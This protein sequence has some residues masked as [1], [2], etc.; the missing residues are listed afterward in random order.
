MLS[1]EQHELM[2]DEHGFQGQRRAVS[3]LVREL[4]REITPQEIFVPIEHPPGAEIQIDWG[5]ADFILNGVT[6]RVMLFCARLP[7]SKATYVRAYMREDQ[8]SFLDAHVHLIDYLKGVPHTFAYDNLKSAVTK[9]IGRE[10]S[11]SKKFLELRSHYLFKT[12]FCNVARGNEKGH[13]ENAVKRTQRNYMT[14]L[15]SVTSIDQLNEHLLDR[16]KADLERIDTESGKSYGEL[17]EIERPHFAAIPHATFTAC[18]NRP[19]R[20]D[21]YAT[22]QFDETRYSVP[23][24]YAS[25]HSVLRVGIETVEVIVDNEIVARHDRGCQGEWVLQ[26]DHYLP[27]LE[28]KPGLLDSGKPNQ[29][30][31]KREPEPRPPR[32]PHVKRLMALAIRLEDLLDNGLVGNQS[33]IARAAGISTA[34]VSQIVNLNR[35]A[36]DIQQTILELESTTERTDPFLE[37]QVREIATHI[38]WVRQRKEFKKLL[39]RTPI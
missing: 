12:R 22:V 30:G 25:M 10:R 14:P 8:P 5:E 11:L 2:R 29:H 9:I 16:C 13:T 6:T 26:M 38:N 21:R 35:L 15:P 1:M 39:S 33:E 31:A 32:V 36:P 34:R 4:R 27:I 24:R 7:Y 28:R 3:D 17:L 37:R 18:I 20:V 19:A 23:C